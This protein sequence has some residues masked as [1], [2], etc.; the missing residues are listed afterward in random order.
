MLRHISAFVLVV[1]AGLWNL[2][3]AQA[4][5]FNVPPPASLSLTSAPGGMRVV[6]RGATN[7]K[8]LV[9]VS[10]NLNLSNGWSLLSSNVAVSQVVAVVDSP[11][12][13]RPL[14]MY[15]AS[16]LVTPFFYQGT[17]GGT[18]AG[19]FI[20]LART[21][22]TAAFMAYNSTAAHRRGEFVNSLAIDGDDVAYGSFIAGTTGA[23]QFTATNTLAGRFTN[24]SSGATGTV[25]AV[26]RANAGI[27]SGSAG[28]YA[29]P[30][31]GHSGTARILLCPDGGM[32]FFR[33]D[34]N[35][36]K[37]DGGVGA[38]P[39]NGVVDVYLSGSVVM[40]V[41]GSFNPALKRFTVTIHE[42]DGTISTST[43]TFSEP[44][45]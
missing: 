4:A 43:L 16:S 1:S 24:S 21:N 29:G 11:S 32:A 33:N 12:T 45:L 30:M 41:A 40:H 28:L 7:F 44:I 10:T 2:P 20:L 15:K 14:R 42:L 38:L 31:V 22:N 23:L 36:G 26:Q 13:N 8:F 18:E 3:C 9:Y 37:N 19:S 17:F 5:V 25:T 35:T 39:I 6:L 34:I 27:H